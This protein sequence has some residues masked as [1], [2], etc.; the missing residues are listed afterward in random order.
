MRKMKIGMRKAIIAIKETQNDESHEILEENS[1]SNE[2]KTTEVNE[3]KCNED[4]P[5]NSAGQTNGD[6]KNKEER[7]TTPE[8][9]TTNDVKPERQRIILKRSPIDKYQRPPSPLEDGEIQEP[10][11]KSRKITL[12][13]RTTEESNPEFDKIIINRRSSAGDDNSDRRKRLSS[14]TEEN[15]LTV[16]GKPNKPSQMVKLVRDFT[17]EHSE[18]SEALHRVRKNVWG[19]SEFLDKLSSNTYKIDINSIKVVCPTVEFLKESE[20]NLKEFYEEPVHVD[21]EMGKK[22]KEEE[23]KS[24]EESEK[25][26]SEEEVSSDEQKIEANPNIIALNRKIS[27]VEDTA[28]NMK[29][30]PSP[31]KHPV[32]EILYITN[33]VRPFTVKQLRELLERTGKI[34]EDGFWTDRI[35]SKCYAVYE[36]LEEAEATRNALHGVYWPIG[37][38]KQLLIDYATKEEME[39]ARNPV[40]LPATLIQK[41][42]DIENKEPNLADGRHREKEWN[43]DVDKTEKRR[44]MSTRDWDK[45][46]EEHRRRH[47]RSRSR[48]RERKNSRR[49]YTPADH[50]R[51]KLKVTDDSVPQ[52]LMDD[53]FLKTKAMPSIYWQPLSPQE[54]ATKQQ[55]RLVRMEEHKR[56][57]ESR[58]RREKDRRGSFRRR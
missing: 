27:I 1:E 7:S 51:K 11:E 54:I 56:R 45:G 38:G 53:L 42:P 24:E 26:P 33:L 13:R 50:N 43:R 41:L 28:A 52:K 12:K 8:P 5:D 39:G 21:S 15:I 46:K 40:S 30:P 16:V 23:E 29:P 35:K 57:I 10:K 49:S 55:Q 19:K 44:D 18:D 37:N 3:L 36:N 6:I 47:S 2:V 31:A 34:K 48:E 4:N 20:V 14:A 9:K 25:E 17:Q 22:M 58:S 32:S